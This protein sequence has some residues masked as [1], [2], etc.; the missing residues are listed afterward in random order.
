MSRLGDN[1]QRR[2]AVRCATRRA[3]GPQAGKRTARGS[4]R[5]AHSRAGARST[6]AVL[7]FTALWTAVEGTPQRPQY[8]GP[9]SPADLRAT[10]SRLTSIHVKHSRPHRVDRSHVARDHSDETLTDRLA[11]SRPP[12]TTRGD[13]SAPGVDRRG[14][15]HA[16]GWAREPSPWT[17]L[18]ALTTTGSWSPSDDRIPRTTA[19]VASTG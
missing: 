15:Q 7:V 1:G 10:L 19:G 13:A 12:R 14:P 16:G 9:R 2:R 11:D 8:C 6:R 5:A 3:D 17:W 4:R 18:T